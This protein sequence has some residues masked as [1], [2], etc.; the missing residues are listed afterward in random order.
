MN[1]P[2]HALI[3]GSARRIG[4][5]IALALAEQGFDITIHYN[6]SA[7]DAQTLAKTITSMGR[8]A[9]IIQADLS[10]HEGIQALAGAME[11]LDLTALINNANLFMSDDKDPSGRRH[12]MVNVIAPRLLS[13]AFARFQR[14]GSIVTLL[15]STL[16][17]VKNMEH[18]KQSRL[19][20]R[21]DI[22]ALA[23]ALAPQ[24]TINAINLGPTLIAASQT[25]EHFNQLCACTP[26]KKPVALED[27]TQGILFLLSSQSITGSFLDID[28][29]C[30]LLHG[31]F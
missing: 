2:P 13:E 28:N 11:N 29:G 14:K 5:A 27:I 3:T 31:N 30:H 12:H 10:N 16:F 7:Q 18:Y 4:R 17:F 19:A 15:D 20:A 6:T 26:L 1:T 8:K 25:Q 21:A 9:Q 22:F 24:V 23:K